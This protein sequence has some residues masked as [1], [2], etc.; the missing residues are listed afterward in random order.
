M[1]N[2]NELIDAVNRSSKEKASKASMKLFVLAI[3]AGI[4]IAFGAIFYTTV[5]AYGGNPGLIKLV[6]GIVFSLGLV[7]VVF[8]GAEL[9]TGNN[10]MVISFLNKEITIRS[11][12]KNWMIVY[13]GN[14]VGSLVIVFLM[15]FT[16]QYLQDESIIGKHALL[17]ANG[18]ISLGFEAAFFRAILCNTL[19]CLAVWL[20]MVAKTFSGK[21]IG[22]IFP[23]SAFV[24]IGLEHSIANMYFVPMG[25]LIKNMAPDLFWAH[26]NISQ[27]L[28]SDLNMSTFI[29]N[30]LIPVTIGNIVGG[31]LFVA[32][33]YWFIH[34]DIDKESQQER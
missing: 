1:R 14:L 8:A 23:I 15:F 13:L 32:M 24:A 34:K 20:T 25:I 6:G 3:L 31:V 21:V 2:S 7:L 17:I 16:K 11:L 19:V 12:L 4:Y 18:K 26:S 5:T 29:F 30:N 27:N 33:S 10:L 28:F 9:F 22:I